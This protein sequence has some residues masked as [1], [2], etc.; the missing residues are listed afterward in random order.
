MHIKIYN[1]YLVGAH[2]CVRPKTVIQPSKTVNTPISP[3]IL[4]QG[5]G[6]H[7]EPVL[8]FSKGPSKGLPLHYDDLHHPSLGDGVPLKHKARTVWL[9]NIAVL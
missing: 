7:P 9:Q 1:R 3:G 6:R 5:Q 8:R 2:L 4:G